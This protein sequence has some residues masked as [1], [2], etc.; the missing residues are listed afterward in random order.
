MLVDPGVPLVELQ[1]FVVQQFE[2]LCAVEAL[3]GLVVLVLHLEKVQTAFNV[4]QLDFTRPVSFRFAWHSGEMIVVH[5]LHLLQFHDLRLFKRERAVVRDR[6]LLTFLI[7]L[8]DYIPI[9][10]FSVCAIAPLRFGL[11]LEQKFFHVV[12]I[13]CFRKVQFWYNGLAVK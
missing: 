8:T 2:H 12:I 5:H 10:P 11:K 7:N 4:L 1:L 3:E 6:V 13:L 9:V